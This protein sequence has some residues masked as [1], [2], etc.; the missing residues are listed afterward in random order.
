MAS[1]V[2]RIA[3][4]RFVVLDHQL[5]DGAPRGSHFDLM[6][7]QSDGLET[8][9]LERWPPCGRMHVLRLP[10]HA[11]RYL[12]YEGPISNDR[13]S[14]RRVASGTYRRS[15]TDFTAQEGG[16]ESIDLRC[17]DGSAIELTLS[18]EL[19]PDGDHS[20]WICRRASR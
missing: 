3:V 1:E 2:D 18:A 12:T 13:G 5:P 6:L 9:A 19:R 14:V 4:P 16:C 15:I 8:Y 7:E 17:D 20:W 11:V 10:M